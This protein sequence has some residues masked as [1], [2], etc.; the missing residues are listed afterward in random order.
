MGLDEEVKRCFWEGLDKVVRGV[1][2]LEKLFIGRDFNGHIGSSAGGYGEVHCGF[3]F[4]DRNGEGTSLLDFT[5]AFELVIANTSFPKREEHLVTFGVRWLRL[6]LYILL[7]LVESID[8]EKRRAKR[9]KYK[10]AR[11]EVKLAVTEANTAAFSRLY[12]ELGDKGGDKK[13]FRLAK[14]RERKAR[15]QDQVRCIKNEEGGVLMADVQIKRR[16]QDYFY[17]LMNKEGDKDIVLGELGHSG[18]HLDFRSND[19]CSGSE[20]IEMGLTST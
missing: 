3:G 11:K 17:R 12:E 4:E 1:P 16:W 13:L 10:E 18:S 5:R 15:D 2:L 6:R 9:E 7:R 14:V 8:E 20:C 19:I